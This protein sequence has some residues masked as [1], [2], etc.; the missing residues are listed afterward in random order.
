V[1]FHAP[2]HGSWLNIAEIELAALGK[3]CL[4]RRLGSLAELAREAG[5]DD[6]D[7]L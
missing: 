6:R 5:L 3:Q 1:A 4:G 7:A 2:W